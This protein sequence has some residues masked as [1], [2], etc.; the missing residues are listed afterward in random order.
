MVS[1]EDVS[2]QLGAGAGVAQR[3]ASTAGMQRGGN[4]WELGELEG[5]QGW[6]GRQSL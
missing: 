6:T 2:Q 4:R 3:A 5:E 1:G